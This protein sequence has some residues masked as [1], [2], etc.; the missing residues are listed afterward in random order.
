ML[1]NPRDLPTRGGT[2]ATFNVLP[3]S[4]TSTPNRSIRILAINGANPSRNINVELNAKLLKTKV[5][6][7]SSSPKILGI[8]IIFSFSVFCW[9]RSSLCFISSS[10]ASLSW[11]LICSGIPN[12]TT[13][14]KKHKP[15]GPRKPNHQALIQRGSWGV[16]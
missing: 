7:V 8:S 3:T 13:P 11:L 2:R 15:A 1:K 16:K 6:F 10:S 12:V 14:T 4:C 5:Q 9:S